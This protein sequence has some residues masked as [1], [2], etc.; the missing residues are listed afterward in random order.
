[1]EKVRK[2]TPATFPR[3]LGKPGGP[4]PVFVLNEEQWKSIAELSGISV[5]AADARQE[6]NVIIGRYRRFEV[7]D[8]VRV[9][10]AKT[11]RELI[12]LKKDTQALQ[13]RLCRLIENPDAHFVLTIAE[14]EED[15]P[16]PFPQPPGLEGDDPVENAII[17]LGRFGVD[18]RPP[19]ECR[20]HL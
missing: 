2:T 12:A 11:R 10:S 14:L 3:A 5:N 1:M 9:P 20:C 15:M 19:N 17:A 7:N 13:F 18:Q 4:L 8:S 6:F 16:S